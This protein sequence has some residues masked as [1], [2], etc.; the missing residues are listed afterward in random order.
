[1]LQK[2]L[3]GFLTQGSLNGGIFIQAENFASCG[4]FMPPNTS[5]ENV[6][7]LPSAGIFTALWEIGIGCFKVFWN[8][9]LCLRLDIVCLIP[10]P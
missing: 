1:M 6:W 9:S 10:K 7:T 8:P 2:L 3:S 5:M 4:L